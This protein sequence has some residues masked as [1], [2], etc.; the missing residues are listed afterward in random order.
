MTL[1]ER[2][3]SE[4]VVRRRVR[5][6]GDH[7]ARLIPP[8]AKVLDIGCGDGSLAK[9]V[10]EK[11]PDLQLR[12]MDVLVRDQTHIPVEAFDGQAIP[13]C[14]ASFDAV[15]LVDVLHHTKDPVLLLR[16][17]KRVARTAILVKDHCLNGFLAGPILEFMDRVGNARHGVALTYNYWPQ[18]QWFEA[19]RVLGLTIETWTTQLGLYP[20]PT[21]WIFERSLHFVAR[22]R[23]PPAR[24][25][26]D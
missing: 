1:C 12:G 14:D 6:L 2:I 23:F 17:A 24:K 13:H 10:T 16:E 3:H 9:R 20:W 15:L 5:V 26:S 8:N 11:R 25:T 21:R 7:L 4:Y 19:C 18:Q 22:L